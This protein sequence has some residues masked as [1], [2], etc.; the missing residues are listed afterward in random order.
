MKKLVIAVLAVLMMCPVAFGK[1][2][3]GKDIPETYK[4]GNDT[5]VLNGSGVREKW[6]MDIYATGLYLK[7]K[8]SDAEQIINADEPLAVK[9][10]VISG[11]MTE[12]K[13]VNALREGFEKA[14]KGNLNPIRSRLDKWIAGHAGE[15]QKDDTYDMVY[16]PGEG[17]SLF[18]NGRLKTTIEGLDFKK[19]YCAMY[20]GDDPVSEDLKEGMLGK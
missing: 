10:I 20:L 12:E 9:I 19:A 15:I 4:A 8:S 5:L 1:D 16:I 2:V 6:F 13:M 11:L 7:S 18:K 3:G 17:L 14:T